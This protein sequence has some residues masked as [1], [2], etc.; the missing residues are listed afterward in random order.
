MRREAVVR[1]PRLAGRV[2]RYHTWPT[3]QDQ[4][5]A[6]HTW[7]VMRI[8]W[9]V[10]GPLSPEV[11]THLLWHDGGE[12]A[13]GDPPFP[14]KARDPILK[15]RYDLA[16]RAALREI[17]GEMA[18]RA[19]AALSPTERLRCKVCDLLEMTEFGVLEMALGN[20]LAEPIVRDTW[21]AITG[22]WAGLSADERDRV[23]LHYRR[24]IETWSKE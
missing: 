17:A 6:D 21:E 8:Y 16:E 23:A 20:T 15:E 5:N 12:L 18:A 3:L 19:S 13:V 2:R 10:F 7:H 22:M 4:T 24:V 11:S 1:S 9:Q 14:T